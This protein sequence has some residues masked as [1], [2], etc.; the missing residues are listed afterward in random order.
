L[1]HFAVLPRGSC[2][3]CQLFDTV[4]WT[5]WH[6]NWN[7]ADRSLTDYRTLRNR[8]ESLHHNVSWICCVP[9]STRV[10]NILLHWTKP[11]FISRIISHQCWT[12]RG[13]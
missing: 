3:Q 7:I 6:I 10:G 11:G 9:S 5:R 4:W 12:L 2:F 13:L 8:P 1:R